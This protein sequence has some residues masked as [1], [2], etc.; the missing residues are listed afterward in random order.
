M[1]DL[2]QDFAGLKNGLAKRTV[3]AFQ[4]PFFDA[5][6]AVVDFAAIAN[7]RVSDHACHAN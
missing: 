6:G 3:F 4:H 7:L 1:P 2:A 5:F